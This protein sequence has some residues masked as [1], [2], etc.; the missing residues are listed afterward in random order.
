MAAPTEI[1]NT[2]AKHQFSDNDLLFLRNATTRGWSLGTLESQSRQVFH[3]ALQ[4]RLDA[5]EFGCGQE[6]ERT[7]PTRGRDGDAAW[8]L[9]LSSR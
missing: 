7:V 4:T 2:G 1:P 5:G 3:Q 9:A 8:E 6:R